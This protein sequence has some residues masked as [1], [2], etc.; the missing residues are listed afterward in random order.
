VD[1][2]RNL[3]FGVLALQLD[4]IDRDAF[5]NACAAWATRKDTPLG[6]VF[7][8]LG[9]LTADDRREVERLMERRLKKHG[10]DV[11]ASLLAIADE[12]VR[13]A[14]AAVGDQDL[15]R[16]LP[17][18]PSEWTSPPPTFAPSLS[19]A[20][21]YATLRLAGSG[22]LGRVWLVRDTNLG[23]EVAL[24][25]LRPDHADPRYWNRFVHEAQV[26]GQL[27]HPGI[28]PIYDAGRKPD[29]DQPFY[30]MR[31]VRGRTLD[32]AI[33]VYHERRRRGEAG[34]LELRELLGAFVQVC[35][36]IGYAHSRGV[37]HRDLK[38]HNVALGDYGEVMVLDWG[39]AKVLS[40]P[41]AS[42]TGEADRESSTPPPVA[43]GLSPQP[44]QAGAVLGTPA[45]MA[46]EQAEGRLDLLDGRSD[47]Y[48]LGA[49]LYQLLTGTAPFTGDDTAAVLN[50][51][52]HDPP[53]RPRELVAGTPPALEAVCLK[54][55]AKRREERYPSAKALAAE[56]QRL[57]ADEPVT[58][59]RDPLTVRLTRWGRRHRTA[60]TTAAALVLTATVGLAVG[61]WLVNAEKDRTAQAQ[62]KTQE[63]LEQVTQEQDKTKL[64]FDS[65]S[66]Q[67]RLA[68]KTVRGVV[69]DIEARLKD[70]P[71]Q[72]ELRKALLGRALSGL[73]EVARA[74]D[75]ATAI[76]DE[77]I[78]VHFELGDIFLEIEEGGSAEAKKQYG[79]AHELARQFWEANP[80]SV[81]AQHDLSESHTKLGDVYLR[82]GDSQTALEHYQKGLEM[83]QGLADANQTSAEVQRVLSVSYNKLGDVYDKRGDSQA[84]LDNYK[85]GLEVRQPLAEAN[86]ESAKAQRDLAISYIKLGDVYL[87]RRGDRQAA[88]EHYKKALEIDQR[89]ADADAERK[90]AQAQRDL[91]VSH[92][93]LGDV[94]LELGDSQAALEHYQKGLEVSQ[95]LFDAD[96]TSAQAQRDLAVSYIKLGKVYLGLKD[97]KAALETY[98]KGL[99][100]AQRLANVDPTSALAQRD[101][102]VFHEKL[103]DVYLDELGDSK[104][105]LE[106]YQNRLEISQRLFDADKASAEAQLDMSVAHN[107]LGD[108]YLKLG[109]SKAAL[110]A[111]KK[112]LELAQG[113]AD[114]DKTSAQAQLALISTFSYLGNV[115]EQTYD[116]KRAQDWYGQGLDVPKRFP[117]PEVFKQEVTALEELVRFCRA[118]EQAVA[119]PTTALK[120]PDDQR[121]PVLVAAMVA[122]AKKEKQPAKAIAAAD[123]LAD[124]A[125]APGDWYDAACGYAL[126]IPLADKA[127]TK[128]KYAARAV[129]LLRQAVAKGYKD[130]AQMKKDTDLDA[131]RPR[132][133][134]KK[135]VADL[136]AA[137]KPKDKKGP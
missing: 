36:A 42:A 62:Q 130:V 44:T 55:L 106:H 7:V 111:C 19:G 75:T 63:A 105:A 88:L 87:R 90:S 6:E 99:E 115:A 35:Q 51:V 132:D 71:G 29:S 45:Y 137:T 27:E 11:Q 17:P 117:K 9:L 72:K 30:T 86:P 2:D 126:C 118:A 37:L 43:P 114:R 100:V 101:L 1:T 54:A 10:G 13:N 98:K 129:E 91:A 40:E 95:R 23:R 53:R 15:A 108:V 124:N 89:L 34:P 49:I 5:V 16:S 39:L 94:Y 46:P 58:A 31:F 14:V 120:L 33:A 32:H 64:A 81:P 80:D 135:L 112:A 123:L 116:F 65:A 97:S 59:Y 113:L 74:A 20:T 77:T 3:L 104:A 68:L 136:E 25:E 4:L 12:D 128:E 41:E 121:R 18:T 24:K 57:L 61:L 52:R 96:K 107:K 102:A 69:N 109:D 60:V 92:D 21:R 56:V 78:W 79:K 103:G 125:K 70:R 38:P 50:Q 66:E 73:A 48:G 85:K 67:R 22:G 82:L 127:E 110:E 134:F 28:V 133:D 26:T 8:A 47:V 76:D 84:A 93:S 119:D 131:L 122:L 83:W